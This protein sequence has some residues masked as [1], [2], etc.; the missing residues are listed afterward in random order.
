MYVASIQVYQT[1]C[2]GLVRG[3]LSVGVSV[4]SQGKTVLGAQVTITVTAP[5]GATQ[6]L[7]ATSG[8]LGGYARFSISPLNAGVYTV[9]VTNVTAPNMTYMPAL[10]AVSSVTYT[11]TSSTRR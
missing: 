5:T 11:V 4:V 2:N 3:C 8:G 7:I 9:T 6:T 1:T 10:N